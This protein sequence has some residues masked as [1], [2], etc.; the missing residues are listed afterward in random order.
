VAVA[1]SAAA[2]EAA[3]GDS[4]A[5]ADFDGSPAGLERAGV[6]A[7]ISGTSAGIFFDDLK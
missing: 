3:G 6:L 7:G 1:A 4:T 5:A 2:V